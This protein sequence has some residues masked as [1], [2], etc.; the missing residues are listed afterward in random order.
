MSSD[1]RGLFAERGARPRSRRGDEPPATPAAEAPTA[2]SEPAAPR[3]DA[4]DVLR[5]VR[6]DVRAMIDQWLSE[7]SH[8]ISLAVTQVVED[9][10]TQLHAVHAARVRELTAAYEE[11]LAT[12]ERERSEALRGAMRRRRARVRAVEAELRERIERL[13]RSLS[14]ASLETVERLREV[15]RRETERRLELERG[16]QQALRDRDDEI[17]RLRR[18]GTGT[19]ETLDGLAAQLRSRREH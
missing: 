9:A 14:E 6:Q 10:L 1:D 12:A 7:R 2:A 15:E 17:A 16:F 3:A 8:T 11:K 13:E 5:G 19:D 4:A 18:G